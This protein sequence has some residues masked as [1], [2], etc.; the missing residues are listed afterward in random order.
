[1]NKDTYIETITNYLN[2]AQEAQKITT[3][4][5]LQFYFDGVIEAY[6]IAL[7]HYKELNNVKNFF[8]KN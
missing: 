1:M 5:E 3:V 7:K 8:Y 6:T 4:K 2:M